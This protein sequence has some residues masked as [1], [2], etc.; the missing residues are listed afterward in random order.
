MCEIPFF[1]W[2]R[3]GERKAKANTGN[4]SKTK[5]MPSSSHKVYLAKYK[6]VKEVV[7]HSGIDQNAPPERAK[8]AFA[9][10][11]TETGA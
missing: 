7:A 1:D 11:P 5:G 10:T 4:P 3:A 9:A 2:N 8:M 6:I